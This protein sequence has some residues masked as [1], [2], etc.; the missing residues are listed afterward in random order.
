[1]VDTYNSWYLSWCKLLEEGR[2]LLNRY[3]GQATDKKR[4]NDM[5]FQ[6]GNQWTELGP[7]KF[8]LKILKVNV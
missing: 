3:V 7:Q 6:V 8:R 5:A 1:M 4:Q 2:Y